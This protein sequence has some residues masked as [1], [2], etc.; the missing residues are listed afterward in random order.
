MRRSEI[1]LTTCD[2]NPAYTLQ[3]QG[4]DSIRLDHT[5]SY[6]E[7]VN[8]AFDEPRYDR[9]KQ[10]PH[11]AGA[12][13]AFMHKEVKAIVDIMGCGGYPMLLVYTFDGPLL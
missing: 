7:T 12:S 3:Q 4:L 11:E 9:S 5:D 1:G 6:I 10:R 2:E 13:L 8:V